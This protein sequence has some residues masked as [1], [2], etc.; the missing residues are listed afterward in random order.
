MPDNEKKSQGDDPGPIETGPTMNAADPGPIE[1]GNIAY[2]PA[3]DAGP[4][5]VP[6]AQSDGDEGGER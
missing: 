1:I 3:P 5:V 4:A 6:E 2:A